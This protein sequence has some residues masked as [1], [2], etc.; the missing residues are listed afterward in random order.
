MSE[1]VFFKIGN[2]DLFALRYVC[3]A[4]AIQDSGMN[5]Y[6]CPVIKDA[7]AGTYLQRNFDGCHIQIPQNGGGFKWRLAQWRELKE[8]A[9]AC[10]YQATKN[11][12]SR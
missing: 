11:Q 9:Q 8:I 5:I 12:K 6:G 2:I 10:P 3:K 4:C 1:K 7:K